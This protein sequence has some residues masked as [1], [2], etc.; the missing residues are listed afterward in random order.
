MWALRRPSSQCSR[1]PSSRPRCRR[2]RCCRRARQYPPPRSRPSRPSPA[3]PSVRAVSDS[4]ADDESER[5]RFSYSDTLCLAKHT[6]ES[7]LRVAR[8]AVQGGG[9][10]LRLQLIRDADSRSN[11]SLQGR[12]SPRRLRATGQARPHDVHAGNAGGELRSLWRADSSSASSESNRPC[13]RKE[14]VDVALGRGRAA[15]LR[16]PAARL[17]VCVLQRRWRGEAGEASGRCFEEGR[18]SGY[19]GQG[20]E[21]RAREAQQEHRGCDAEEGVQ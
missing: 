15:A 10:D 6:P 13:F 5:M 3:A 8:E 4:H 21:R 9:H 20:G 17:C 7:R 1:P 14:S 12:Q 11:S 18:R 16:P 19:A 2:A